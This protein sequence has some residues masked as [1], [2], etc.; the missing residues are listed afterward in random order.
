MASLRV[1]GKKIRF[2]AFHTA[3]VC[4][5]PALTAK[6]N[7]ITVMVRSLV[8]TSCVY[9][10]QELDVPIAEGQLPVF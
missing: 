4:C 6:M 8:I 7:N 9:M 3:M 1:D 10:H 2:L 5:Q